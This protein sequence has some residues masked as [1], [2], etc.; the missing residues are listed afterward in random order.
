[1][2]IERFSSAGAL[3]FS[4]AVRAGDFVF[5]T[6]QVAS[7]PDGEIVAGGIG[8]QATRTIENVKEILESAGLGLK[9]VVKAMVWL[10]DMRDFAGFNR[11]Y[12]QYFGAALPARSCVQAEL[13]EPDAKVEVEVIAYSP[14][15]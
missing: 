2:S 3:P 11:V 1:M 12:A 6:G 13:V 5:V 9:D 10:S 4:K 15:G 7:G 8:P 14:R